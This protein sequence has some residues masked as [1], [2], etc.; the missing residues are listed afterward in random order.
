MCLACLRVYVL[1]YLRSYVLGVL[2]CYRAYVLM[3]LRAWPAF[4]LRALRACVLALMKCFTFLRVCVLG[5]LSIGVLTF[6]FNYSFCLQKS[7]LC[8]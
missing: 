2:G 6:L 7:R 8:S 5:V 3:C 1:A 4:V